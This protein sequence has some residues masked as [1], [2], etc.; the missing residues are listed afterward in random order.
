MWKD[1]FMNEKITILIRCINEIVTLDLSQI[2]NQSF[3]NV[4]VVLF[5]FDTDLARKNFKDEIIIYP[6]KDFNVDFIHENINSDYVIILNENEFFSEENSL[7][8]MYQTMKDNQSNLSI[9]SSILLKNTIFQFYFTEDKIKVNR[10]TENNVWLYTRRYYEFRKISGVL[11]KKEL[12]T[13]LELPEQMILSAMLK[14]AKNPIFDCHSY[15]VFKENTLHYTEKFAWIPQKLPNYLSIS[16]NINDREIIEDKISI[17]LCINV[18]YSKYLPTIIYSIEKNCQMKVDIYIVYY[19]VDSTM[20]ES[21]YALNAT[22]QRVNIFLRKIPTYQYEQLSKINR[23]YS[24]L[25]IEAYFRLLLP[26]LLPQLQ[27]VLYL[28]VDMLV[29]HDLADLWNTTFD[30]NF[31]IAAP[32]YP[33]IQDENSWGYQLLDKNHGINYINSGMLLINLVLFR[34]YDIFNRFIDFVVDT[35]K[36][37]VLDDQDAYNLFFNEYIK[38]TSIWNNFI[39]T[40]LS[41]IDFPI[42]QINIVHY[43]GYSRPKPWTLQHQLPTIQKLLVQKYRQY[44][45]EIV[46]KLKPNSK[47]AIFITIP[48]SINQALHKIETIVVQQESN[49][50]L[51]LFCPDEQLI[52]HLLTYFGEN[53]P[54]NLIQEEFNFTRVVTILKSTDYQYVYFLFGENR[55]DNHEAFKQLVTCADDNHANLIAS[56]YVIYRENK[57]YFYDFNNQLMNM[58]EVEYQTIASNWVSSEFRIIEGILFRTKILVEYLNKVD[59]YKITESD[60]IEGVYK[61]NNRKYYLSKRFWIKVE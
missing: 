19:D 40:S 2:N 27:R 7:E 35:S 9:S 10:L 15:Y 56:S 8:K 43:C 20:L 32:D 60:L 45:K 18:T 38:L 31:L 33:M 25:P 26:K 3:S 5:V 47:I 55:M 58:D 50:E 57:Y 34:E 22:L 51:F 44:E 46:A 21:I 30:G 36:F 42:E 12:L 13:S 53:V 28:D 14:H 61:Q 52:Q 39:V 17:A 29:L 41:Y 37:Y 4:E 54:Y 48:S 11:F 23:K 16:E 49:F 24:K 59:G 1:L 6:L